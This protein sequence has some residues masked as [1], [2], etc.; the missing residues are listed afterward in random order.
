[1]PENIR[2]IPYNYTSYSDREIVKR[3]LGEEIWNDLNVLR[4]QRRTGRSARMLFEILGDV[5]VIERNVF[6]KNDLLKHPKRLK[7]MRKRHQER[8]QRIS[9]G[10]SDNPRAQKVE[11]C[12][13]R[14]LN[15]F[16]A[17]FDAEPKK[18]RQTKKILAKYTH[19][20]NIHFD[21]F[22]LSH[23]ATDATDWRSHTPFCVVTPD[24]PD[25]I[26]GLV[27]AIA[28]M[29]LV[30]IPRGGGT[31]LCGGSVPLSNNVVMINIEKFDRIDEV[32]IQNIGEK[33]EVATITAWA[34]AVTGKVME[35][36][37]PHVFATDP[38]SLW[39]CTIGGNVASNAGGKHAVIWGTCV[40]NLLGWKMVT[41]DGNW[42]EVERLNHNMG[43]LH[44]EQEVSFK[45]TRTSGKDGSFISEEV[46]N[47]AGSIFRK[48]GLGKDVTRKAMGGLPGIQKEGTD[49]FIT[50]ATFVLHR[51][52]DV[53][54][55][56]CCEF[57][58]QMLDDATKALVGIKEHVDAM[59]AA[60]IEGFEHFDEKY[61]KA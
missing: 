4:E 8:L 57:F 40:D 20:N 54:R 28:D 22:T 51:A 46:M 34:G 24:T 36:S 43:K 53:T 13:E 39:A 59:D 10:A 35:A 2:E 21:A 6:L 41:P 45:V 27:S 55:T 16:Y 5:W 30:I 52:Y 23:H 15:E 14:M 58:G 3:F 19:Q 49:G 60:Y 26:P 44:D 7:Q 18:R 1:M 17:W 48:E 33:G 25:E 37:K 61:V 9:R 31:G 38:T 50:E 47:I 29:E 11:A 56:V 42:L 12:T 32:K